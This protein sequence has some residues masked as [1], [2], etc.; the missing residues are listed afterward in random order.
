MEQFDIFGG[1]QKSDEQIVREYLAAT[2]GIAPTVN[3]ISG[4][5]T[6]AY[7]ALHYPAEHNVF[8]LVLTRDP[9]CRIQDKG[10]L[11]AI[12]EKC[13]EFEGSRELDQTLINLLRLEQEMGKEIT[14]VWGKT[15]D[16]VI[17]SR[18]MLPNGRTRFCTQEM[19]LAPMFNW[20]QQHIGLQDPCEMRIG[21]RSDETSRVY[22]IL[23]GSYS[24]DRGWDWS[25]IGS[26]ERIPLSKRRIQWRFP[27]SPLWVDGIDHHQVKS[28]WSKKGWEFPPVSNCDFCF[29]HKPKEMI[30]Q[31]VLHPERSQWWI[32]QE[33]KRG[34][35]FGKIQ[36]NR[37]LS[38][39]P[40]PLFD[41]DD[42][43]CTD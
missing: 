31:Q 13:P 4:G 24:K 30:Q 11:R 12:R 2:S 42:C 40:L 7:M 9:N 36:L 29:F 10:L 5:K 35:T 33:S 32:E 14:W 22:K 39:D 3:S 15:F 41:D 37:I 17:E 16:E 27:Q 18:S 19:K 20:Y 26:C 43:H 38:G 23:G 28:F 6:S 8:A 21:F 1:S 25:N 34:H